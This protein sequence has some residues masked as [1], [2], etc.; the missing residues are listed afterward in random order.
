MDCFPWF[1]HTKFLVHV[2]VSLKLEINMRQYVARIIDLKYNGMV[3]AK[4]SKAKLIV[5]GNIFKQERT[6]G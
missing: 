2:G 3:S 5:G 1:W 4:Q 6:I